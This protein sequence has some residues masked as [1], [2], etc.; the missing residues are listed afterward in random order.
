MKKISYEESFIEVMYMTYGKKDLL[1][2]S[3]RDLSNTE[4]WGIPRR[5]I[6]WYPHIDYDRCIGC[7]LCY[8]TCSGRVVYD[9]DF[10]NMKPIVAR[11]YNCLVGC[12]TCA[13]LCPRDAIH[14]PPLGY[15]RKVRDHAKAIIKARNKI[16]SLKEKL[17]IKHETMFQYILLLLVASLKLHA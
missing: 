13:N 8:I 3:I 7:G 9:W 16:I 11:P 14:F 2:R 1:G 17:F 4:W 10:D 6:K 5:E 15:L 12:T